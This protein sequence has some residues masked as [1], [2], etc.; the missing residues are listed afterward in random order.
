MRSI[1]LSSVQLFFRAHFSV[2]N[3]AKLFGLHRVNKKYQINYGLKKFICK[4]R[5]RP[6]ISPKFLSKLGRKSPAR[7]TTLSSSHTEKLNSNTAQE[8]DHKRYE[9]RRDEWRNMG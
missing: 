6:E 4:R 8:R 9:T 2:D 1:V 7:F 3:S 5:I